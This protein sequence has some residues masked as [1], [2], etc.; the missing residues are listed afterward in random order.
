MNK[1]KRSRNS[2]NGRVLSLFEE[3][4]ES[5]GYDGSDE[6]CAIPSSNGS[7]TLSR[8]YTKLTVSSDEWTINRDVPWNGYPTSAPFRELGLHEASF[9]TVPYKPLSL[10]DDDDSDETIG[11]NVPRKGNPTAR[12][13][14]EWGGFDEWWNNRDSE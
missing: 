7:G 2:R 10:E 1:N 6:D 8:D 9:V 14:R 13:L 5:S 11:W 3:N 12:K 4:S